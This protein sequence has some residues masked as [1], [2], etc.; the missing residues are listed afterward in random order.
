[1]GFTERVTHLADYDRN[2]CA[3]RSAY[4]TPLL[5]YRPCEMRGLADP[6]G[7]PAE[8]DARPEHVSR[9]S[10]F[11]AGHPRHV[12]ETWPALLSRD[13]L[14][15][16]VG[17]AGATITRICPVRPL[18]MGANV[19]RYSRAQIDEWVATVPPRLM[20][21]D[22]QND[23]NGAAASA[24]AQDQV[25]ADVAESRTES[26]LDRVRARAGGSKWRKTA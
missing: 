14:C 13:Q 4:E 18:D 12:P 10:D 7:F 21:S 19:V 25:E 15:A 23:A 16:Y 22:K 2:R 26:A 8:S 11:E 17:V 3:A 24:R 6:L 1:M 9:R 5:A 20:V